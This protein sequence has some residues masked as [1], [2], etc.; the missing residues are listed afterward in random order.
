[1][2]EYYKRYLLPNGDRVQE[3]LPDDTIL[4]T[5][6]ELLDWFLVNDGS[7]RSGE[8]TLLTAEKAVDELMKLKGNKE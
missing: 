5:R 7:G 3:Q 2:I 8:M 6:E 1:M 4:V